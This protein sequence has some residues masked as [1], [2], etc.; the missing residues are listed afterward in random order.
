[1]LRTGF[2]VRLTNAYSSWKFDHRFGVDTSGWIREPIPSVEG[3]DAK[4]GSAYDGSN[5][6][7]FKRVIQ[8]LGIRYEDYTFVD[9]GS[10]KGR[11]LLLAAAFPFRSIAGV[12]WSL[13]L[14]EIAGRNLNVYNGP[15]VCH[16]AESF[17]MDAGEFPI[18][19]GKS[20]LYFFN[21][22]KDEIMG[23]V[24]H[25][26]RQS[27]EADPREIILVYMNP[28]FKS[29]FDRSEFLE[30]IVD[31][32]WFAVYSTRSP[33]ADT[34]GNG[35]GQAEPPTSNDEGFLPSVSTSRSARDA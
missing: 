9:F 34:Q 23:R 26:I 24:L 5:P 14:H 28:R 10:G 29:I 4:L 2:A 11:A 17:C 3:S 1:L 25:N 30:K 19:S 33:F 15:R 13:D 12:E 35:M 7:H 31:R 16:E 32:R 27:F 20:V 21:P 8:N 18:P 22:F 6:A